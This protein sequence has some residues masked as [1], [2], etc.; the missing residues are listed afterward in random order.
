MESKSLHRISVMQVLA[1]NWEALPFIGC[2]SSQQPSNHLDSPLS[3]CR[4]VLI[5]LA[6]MILR[7]SSNYEGKIFI[8]PIYMA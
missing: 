8:N 1:M 4:G 2:G 5:L 7:I 6:F 3:F